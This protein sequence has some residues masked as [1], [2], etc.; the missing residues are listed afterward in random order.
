MNDQ[1]N[2]S[3]HTATPILQRPWAGPVFITS[4]ALNLF[5]VGLFSAPLIFGH[6]FHVR[7]DDTGLFTEN[8]PPLP[9]RLMRRGLTALDPRDRVA[10][11]KMMLDA[12]PAIR[13]RIKEMENAK[14]EL[15]AAIAA[16]PYDESRIN[17][18]FDKMD[19]SM[20]NTA[21]AARGS[22]LKGLSQMPAEQRK[23]M[24]QAMSH[25]PGPSM[26][27]QRRGLADRHMPEDED[28]LIDNPADS[29]DEVTKPLDKTPAP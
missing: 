21:R 8:L 20:I 25:M 7:P 4:L 9:D 3:A 27:R 22:M 17:A 26:V 6:R 1:P 12:F 29:S 11:R 5:V 10:M 24:A 19:D 15:V 16:D 14:R 2:T 23:R 28:R 18:A 13:P